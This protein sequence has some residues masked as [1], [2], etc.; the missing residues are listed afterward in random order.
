MK[1]AKPLMQKMHDQVYGIVV[2][3]ALSIPVIAREGADT[4]IRG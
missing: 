3:K 4:R 2:V 1:K